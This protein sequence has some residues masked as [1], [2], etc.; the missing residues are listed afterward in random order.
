[1]AQSMCDQLE[2]LRNQWVEA[3]DDFLNAGIVDVVRAGAVNQMLNGDV[4]EIGVEQQDPDTKSWSFSEKRPR[5]LTQIPESFYEYDSLTNTLKTLVVGNTS[6]EDEH[7]QQMLEGLQR[8][9]C[10]T[11]DEL[12]VMK[13]KSQ[14]DTLRY[15]TEQDVAW[16]MIGDFVDIKDRRWTQGVI[17][18]I[19]VHDGFPLFL[20]VHA[21]G[22][23]HHS[24]QWYFVGD[25]APRGTRTKGPHRGDTYFQRRPYM[26]YPGFV[27]SAA[28]AVDG[29][30][31]VVWENGETAD[32][33]VVDGKWAMGWGTQYELDTKRQSFKW[34][35]GTV[36]TLEYVQDDGSLKWTTTHRQYKVITWVPKA[37]MSDE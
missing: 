31:T 27:V 13:L 18:F 37:N 33:S 5:T 10:L 4:L 7:K 22:E 35:D 36:Q 32:V 3:P 24:D 8:I 19:Q 16:L 17:T 11:M 23:S 26:A 2:E 14:L 28:G 6:D 29:D 20:R 12:D 1:M 30:W 15:L 21:V 34:R 9:A 25:V